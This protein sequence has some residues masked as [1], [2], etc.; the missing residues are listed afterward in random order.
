MKCNKELIS[1]HACFL[2][3]TKIFGKPNKD[4]IRG[5]TIMAGKCEHCG[6]ENQTLIPYSDFQ[7][8]GD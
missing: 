6:R 2:C 8:T 7:G 4:D 1:W 3:G 5:I